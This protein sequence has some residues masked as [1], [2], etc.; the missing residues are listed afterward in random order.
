MRIRTELKRPARFLAIGL[1]GL[2]LAVT[3]LPLLL[4]QAQAQSATPAKPE[5]A[6]DGSPSELA[7][8]GLEQMLRALRLLVQS[9]PQYELPEVLENGDII[10]R[11]KHPQ[12]DSD[13]PE[14]AEPNID[15]TAT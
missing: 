10:I 15:E 9:I 14:N 8:E 2:C 4:G 11:R 12:P 3:P 6:P 7:R 5:D 1:L 13:R